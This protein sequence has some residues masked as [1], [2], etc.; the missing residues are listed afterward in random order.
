MLNIAICDDEKYICDFLK[1]SVTD[2]LAKADIEGNI[3]VFDDGQPLCD[4]YKEGKASFDLIHRTSPVQRK[5]QVIFLSRLTSQL[6]S[7]RIFQERQISLHRLSL[8]ALWKLRE[9]PQ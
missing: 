7:P 1:K 2:C 8:P 3:S 9:S 6:H 5:A 4:L